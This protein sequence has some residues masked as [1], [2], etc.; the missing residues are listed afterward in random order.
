MD[1]GSEKNGTVVIIA[2]PDV[3]QNGL[4]VEWC[5]G[6]LRNSSCIAIC[7]CEMYSSSEIS[8]IYVI[9]QKIL[10]LAWQVG[11]RTTTSTTMYISW[12]CWLFKC[13][14]HKNQMWK[15]IMTSLW[16]FCMLQFLQRLHKG[17]QSNAQWHWG[18]EDI[19]RLRKLTDPK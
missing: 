5:V 11:S 14:N 9:K 4:S 1:P 19:L 10:T 15:Y 16:V 7:R 3:T 6:P 8:S 18:H 13:F 2:L 17:Q 12:T